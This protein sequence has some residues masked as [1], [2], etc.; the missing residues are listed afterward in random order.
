MSIEQEEAE[1]IVKLILPVS[2][3]RDHIQ[4][5]PDAHITLV[6]FEK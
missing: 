6:E 3:S 4:G 1:Q 2:S 5:P